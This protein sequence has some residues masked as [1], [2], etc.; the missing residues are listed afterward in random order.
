MSWIYGQF[1]SVPSSPF[2]PA[3][4]PTP[5]SNIDK[6]NQLVGSIDTVIRESKDIIGDIKSKWDTTHGEL[7]RLKRSYEEKLKKIQSEKNAYG[8]QVKTFKEQ[9]VKLRKKFD[10]IRESDQSKNSSTVIDD[11]AISQCKAKLEENEVKLG[12]AVN[13][14]RETE[15]ES[16]AVKKELLELQ[17]RLSTYEEERGDESS[18]PSDG[19]PG[20]QSGQSD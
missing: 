2:G 16:K 18:G 10:A 15:M 1:P 7:S 13:K 4:P 14:L 20:G 19:P 6:I 12:D 3:T 9:V 8:E 17:T 5:P 11:A